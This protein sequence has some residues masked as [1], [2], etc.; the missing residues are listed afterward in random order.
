MPRKHTWQSRL[1]TFRIWQQLGYNP[2]E[3]PRADSRLPVDVSRKR[4]GDFYKGAF[5]NIPF[6]NDDAKRTFTHLLLRPGY[7]IRDYIK[8]AHDRYLAPFTALIVFYAFF[9]LISAV[10]QPVQ[11]RGQ[12]EI[13]SFGEDVEVSS[14]IVN[15]KR[16]AVV[17]NVALIVRQGYYYLNLDRHPE[18]VLAFAWTKG[19][20]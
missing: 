18:L 4:R 11:Q 6:L 3:K 12:S 20:D 19:A 14:D 15:A 13:L 9:A 2:W 10:L 7:M 5:D 17:K 16:E 8:G 1:R